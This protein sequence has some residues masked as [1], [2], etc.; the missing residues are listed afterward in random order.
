MKKYY[1]AV[2][3]ITT[4]LITFLHLS[5]F[6]EQSPHIV[7]EELYYV[8]LLFGALFFGLKGAVLT[9]LFTSL[10]YLPFSCIEMLLYI[11]SSKFLDGGPEVQTFS[12]L[13]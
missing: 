1:I 13:N 9:Y 10:L 11:T 8:S 4:S 5:I 7:L 6:Q 3:V 12:A 2:I